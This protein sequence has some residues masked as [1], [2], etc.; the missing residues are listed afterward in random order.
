M[1]KFQNKIAKRPYFQKQ[2]VIFLFFQLSKQLL[3]TNFQKTFSNGPK[4]PKTLN[5]PRDEKL[6]QI[7]CRSNAW[8]DD[9]RDTNNENNMLCARGATWHPTVERV[10]AI[11]FNSR[12]N[13]D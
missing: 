10:D 7:M 11:I 6:Q 1:N 13:L 5:P 8:I 4:I 12:F 2:K 3:K 9:T